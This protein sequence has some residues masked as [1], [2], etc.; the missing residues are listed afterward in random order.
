MIPKYLEDLA[1]EQQVKKM[2]KLT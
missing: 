2:Y 1:S